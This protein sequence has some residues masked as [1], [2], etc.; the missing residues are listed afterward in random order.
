[1]SPARFE[2]DP[3]PPRPA[4][5]GRTHVKWMVALMGWWALLLGLEQAG[6]VD[7]EE[8]SF[9]RGRP[10]RSSAAQERSER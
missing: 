4:W 3:E 9:T 5:R 10:E 1:M 2:D 6:C 8:A 7:L